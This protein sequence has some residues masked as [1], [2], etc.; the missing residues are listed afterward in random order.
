MSGLRLTIVIPTVDRAYCVRRA[1]ESALA[2]DTPNLEILVSNNAST[3]DTRTL[4]DNIEQTRSDPRLRVVHH[5]Q[6]LSIVDHGNYLLSEARGDLFLGLSD[7]DWIE[8]AL[9]G[10]VLGLFQSHPELSFV[11][12]G[13][14]MHFGDIELVSP[15][16]PAIEK[17]VDFF[18]AYLAGHRQV[19]WCG[20][21][22]RVADLKTNRAYPRWPYHGRHVLLDQ[23]RISRASGMHPRA[24]GALHLHAGQCVHRY[25]GQRLG[26]G[27][28]R[29][30]E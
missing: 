13:C 10:R 15:V 20:C 8:P 14:R 11:Y 26:E 5:P 1:V 2:Q 12:S 24:T 25:S 16:G 22:T 6:R 18:D 21:I 4:L 17:T 30:R 9:A 23:D 3:D 19:Y 28:G 27:D 7:D 29:G